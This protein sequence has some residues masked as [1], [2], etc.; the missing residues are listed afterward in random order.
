MT[1]PLRPPCETKDEGRDGAASCP[2]GRRPFVLA[3]AVLGSSMVFIDGSA[4]SV[5]IPA[6]RETLGADA[7]DLNWIFNGYTLFLAAF[8]LIGGAAGDR[9]GANRVYGMGVAGFAAASL[10]C[11]LSA[12]PETLIL[13]RAVQGLFGALLTPAAL[14][15]IAAAYPK[16]ER[17]GAIGIWAGASALTTA[18]GPVLGGWLVDAFG[19]QSV[20]FINLPLAAIALVVAIFAA[21]GV[22]HRD[23][24][25]R[26]DLP[27]AGLAALALG[28]LAYGLVALGEGAG[29]VIG[30]IAALL[31]SAALVAAF[32]WRERN[33]GHPMV[34][35]SIFASPV[36]SGV[37]AATLVLYAAL[38]MAF[39][40]LPIEIAQARGWSAVE[41]GLAFLPFS[42]SVG[43]LSG[44]AGKLSSGLPQ[45]LPM[46]LG[47]ALA[48]VGFVMLGVFADAAAWL[49]VYVPMG[50]TGIGFAIVIPTLTAVALSSAPDRFSGLASGVNN[51]AARVASMIG[52]ALGSALL[53]AD[54]VAGGFYVAA[55]L[56]A[57]SAGV[58]LVFVRST[59][60]RTASHTEA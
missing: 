49:A 11:G 24:E 10:A 7:S 14:A 55:G 3:S 30:G 56:A 34:P 28:A 18:G 35:L 60:A 52:V 9:F 42:L 6:L 25:T 46:A 17:G 13:A 37:N 23:T 32:I 38:S 31:A 59:S 54:A 4:L 19:W 27:G 20:F 29:S 5:A 16:E 15:L 21:R 51:A 39:L 12:T 36:F 22:G 50:V 26:F 45:F 33:T 57:A 40:L 44:F 1:H 48:A 8:I 41:I 58:V 47:S 2:K 43:L 53:A